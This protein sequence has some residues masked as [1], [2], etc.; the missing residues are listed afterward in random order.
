MLC[1]EGNAQSRNILPQPLCKTVVRPHTAA[2]ISVLFVCLGNI[3]RSPLAEAALRATAPSHWTIDSAG[4]GN[5]HVGK[6]PDPRSIEVAAANGVDI[7]RYKARQVERA[8]FERFDH[9]I[10]MDRQNLADLQQ[11]ARPGQAAKLHLFLD[12]VSGRE[13][14]SVNDPYYG[15]AADFDVCWA[16]VSAGALAIVSAISS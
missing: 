4:T 5:W 9:I 2:M 3:C 8:D 11:L 10:A 12:F 6:P 7:Q 15:D 1:L 14:Q 16:E 13:G